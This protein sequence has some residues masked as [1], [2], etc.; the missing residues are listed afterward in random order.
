MR[1]HTP[2]RM[3]PM[4]AAVFKNDGATILVTGGCGLIGSATVALLLREFHPR[5]IVL[6][7]NLSSGSLGNVEAAMADR[8]V[9]FG[10]I[11]P[12]EER[13]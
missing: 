4:P 13:S 7:D 12:T 5:R 11:C 10:Q 2:T 8:R 3:N 9:S 1:V 6:L